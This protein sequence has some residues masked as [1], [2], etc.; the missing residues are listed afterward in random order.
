MFKSN[1]VIKLNAIPEEHLLRQDRK[2]DQLLIYLLTVM[3]DFLRNYFFTRTITL[4]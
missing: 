1:Y 4:P 3:M 2:Y